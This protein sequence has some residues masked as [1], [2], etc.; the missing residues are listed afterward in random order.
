MARAAATT[1]RG[2]YAYPLKGGTMKAVLAVLGV[3]CAAALCA[4]ASAMCAG[5]GMGFGGGGGGASLVGGGGGSRGEKKT[6]KLEKAAMPAA[7]SVSSLDSSKIDSILPALKLND[8]QSKRLETLR[9]EVK[10]QL[11]A[12]SKQQNDAR[13]A[14]EKAATESAYYDAARGVM[15]AINAC[16]S[17]DANKRFEAGMLAIL[18]VEQKT[19]YRDLMKS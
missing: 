18:T 4:D 7:V 14:Y 8:E 16:K 6:A 13:S 15:D 11:T 10:Q 12:L 1:F 2:W 5:G 19:A 9:S 17:F 3:I